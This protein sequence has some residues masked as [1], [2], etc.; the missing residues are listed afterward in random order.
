MSHQPV[1]N[2]PAEIRESEGGSLDPAVDTEALGIVRVPTETYRVGG[3]SYTNLTDAIAQGR[4][5][6]SPAERL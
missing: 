5:M 2:P 6:Q 1:S 3:Y 4:R